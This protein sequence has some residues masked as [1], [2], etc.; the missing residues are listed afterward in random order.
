MHN[1]MLEA[2][3][4]EPDLATRAGMKRSRTAQMR[5]MPAVH[6]GLENSM[7]EGEDEHTDRATPSIGKQAGSHD[8]VLNEQELW[9]SS[10]TMDLVEKVPCPMVF[11]TSCT[12]CQ[13]IFVGISL[14]RFSV[15]R[16]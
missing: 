2:A 1:E 8:T 5:S 12:S 16:G 3:L 9:N 10:S 4:E 11:C 7:P 15:S 6:L 13:L 14:P